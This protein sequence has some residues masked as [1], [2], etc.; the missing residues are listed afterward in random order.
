MSNIHPGILVGK[1]SQKIRD[2]VESGVLVFEKK[3]L[4]VKSELAVYNA[5]QELVNDN[6]L[7]CKDIVYLQDGHQFPD[8]VI[9]FTNG[10]SLGI[11]VKSSSSTGKGWSINGNS[12]LGSTS[13]EVTDIYIIFIKF[14]DSTGFDLKYATYQDS[15]ADVVVTHSPRYKIDLDMDL[16]ESPLKN[17]FNRSGISYE[18]IK[19]ADNPI[20]IITDHFRKQGKVAWWLGDSTGEKATSATL[21]SWHDIDSKIA[22]EIY[23]EAIVLFP[24]IINGDSR[25][26]YKNLAKWLAAKHSIID[27]SLRD[28]FSAGGRISNL[29]NLEFFTIKDAPQIY[30]KITYKSASIERAFMN[31]DKAELQSFWSNYDPTDSEDTLMFRKRY[32]Y[33]ILSL[34]ECDEKLDYLQSL[35]EI[36]IP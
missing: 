9:K 20:S 16:K 12:V 24:E 1:I 3:G 4:A 33:K 28:R 11:E 6:S 29:T 30:G 19:K 5:I 15:V 7:K 10:Y 14:N 2:N 23:G 26:K 32:W 21:L 34:T 13:I 31:L 8:I 27:S 18:D 36:D 22:D 25:T 35:F 17:F